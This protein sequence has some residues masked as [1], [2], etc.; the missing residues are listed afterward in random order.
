MLF[1]MDYVVVKQDIK[2]AQTDVINEK[3]KENGPNYQGKNK[4]KNSF[5]LNKI[6]HIISW[7]NPSNSYLTE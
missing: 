4:N 7:R 1:K 5:E 6:L 2:T 3:N